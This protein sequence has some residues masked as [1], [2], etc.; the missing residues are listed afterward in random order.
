MGNMFS[1]RLVGEA[2]AEATLKRGKHAG[3]ANH[4]KVALPG[5]QFS[6]PITCCLAEELQKQAE[7]K[8][9]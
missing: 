6:E 7:G 4:A 1:A 8:Q 3:E 9:H 2:K 5:S